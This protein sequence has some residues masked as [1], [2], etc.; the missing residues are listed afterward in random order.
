VIK[1]D[2]VILAAMLARSNLGLPNPSVDELVWSVKHN[3]EEIEQAVANICGAFVESD[4]QLD[5]MLEEAQGFELQL[6]KMNNGTAREYYPKQFA[7]LDEARE[8]LKTS[9]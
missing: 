4:E 5:I 7:V 9:N 1:S 6:S 3:T 8:L 2:M